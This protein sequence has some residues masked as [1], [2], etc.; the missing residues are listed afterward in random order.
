MGDGRS[1]GVSWLLLAHTSASPGKSL[2]QELTWPRCWD[3][4]RGKE[5]SQLWL[6]HHE[7]AVLGP[8]R[9]SGSLK[10]GSGQRG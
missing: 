1:A 3:S 10:A 6:S 5:A 9:F 8:R 4:L 7:A 2:L